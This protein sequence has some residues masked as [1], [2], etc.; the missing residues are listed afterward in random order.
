MVC[1]ASHAGL[2]PPEDARQFVASLLAAQA[3][4]PVRDAGAAD[5]FARQTAQGALYAAR[6]S[7]LLRARAAHAG[8][9]DGS[10]A[11]STGEKKVQRLDDVIVALVDEARAQDGAVLA[12]SAFIDV[13]ARVLGDDERRVF[14]AVVENGERVVL[15]DDALGPCFALRRARHAEMSLGFDLDATLSSREQVVV[16]LLH[17]GNAA[18]A[19]LLPTDAIVSSNVRP[20]RAD[21]PAK[22]T[23]Q[24]GAEKKTLTFIPRGKEH[25]GFTFVRVPGLADAQCG[26]S[27]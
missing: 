13:V 8:V 24:R 27:P 22:L 18:K 1:G 19:G 25:A 3:T 14:A 11:P 5:L 26:T 16:G 10:R 23:V 7:A 12:K 2:L 20:G 4:L 17:G 15:P 21:V 9:S 6:V